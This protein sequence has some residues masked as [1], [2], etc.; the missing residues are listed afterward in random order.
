MDPR[1]PPLNALRTFVMA[2]RTGS[3]VKAASEL[4]VTPAAVSRSIRSLEDFLGCSLFHRMHRKTS[5]THE[6][7]IYFES[8]ADIFDR[9]ALATQ[10]LVGQRADRPLVICAYPSFIVSWLVPRWSR[11][12]QTHPDVQLRIVT[13]LSHDVSFETKN[14]DLAILSDSVDDPRYISTSL[15][16]TTLIPVC[17]P[18][19]LPPGTLTG[20]IEDWQSALLHCDTRP[21]DWDRWSKANGVFVDTTRGQWFENASM[22]YEA[23]M[24]GLGI[25][26]GIKDLLSR[27]FSSNRLA[28]AFRDNVEIVCRFCVIRP[29]TTETH[30]F[31]PTFMKWLQNEVQAG[32]T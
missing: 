23:A 4:S 19:Y 7:R 24:S 15:F 1:L 20:D 2:A 17:R 16:E 26:I 30:P 12:L 28:A 27:E 29:A 22:M 9:I 18:D 6:G 11:Y 21:G 8:L 25:A 10:G 14:I 5:L 32:S 31:F 13:T 3:F